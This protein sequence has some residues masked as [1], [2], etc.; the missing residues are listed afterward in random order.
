M[1][2]VKLKM[3]ITG[4]N[5]KHRLTFGFEFQVLGGNSHEICS[6]GSEDSVT[7]LLNNAK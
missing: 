5:N 6:I 4:Q 1:L 7:G 2:K 3:R